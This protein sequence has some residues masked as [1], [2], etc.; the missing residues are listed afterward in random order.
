MEQPHIALFLLVVAIVIFVVVAGSIIFVLRRFLGHKKTVTTQATAQT[1]AEQIKGEY[2]QAGLPVNS[3]FFSSP[4]VTG[5]LAGI[6]FSH[7][8]V[9]GGRNS[10]PRIELSARSALRGDFAIRR[11]GGS[12]SFFKSIGIAGEAQTG[13]AAFDGEFY[14]AGTSR[15][16]V[17]A[18]FSDAQNRDAVRALFSLGF[19]SVELGD[20]GIT[21][22]R[23]GHGQLLELS[24]LRSALEQF[25]ALR[26]TPSAMQ[27]AIQGIGGI[28]TR[29]I[30]TAC[31]VALGVAVAA[32]MATTVLLEPMV[33]GQFG[34]FEDSWRSALIAYVSLVLVTLLMLRGR[35]NAPRELVMIALL[36]LP[37]IWVGAVS[38]AMLAN[39]YLDPSPPQTVRVVLL[40]H[41][42]SRG[43]NT[44]Y[45]FVFP[46]WGK[47]R[48]DVNIVVPFDI[49]G[50]ATKKQT[51][52]LH[53]RAGRYGY[54]WIDALKPQPKFSSTKI[55][56]RS[57]PVHASMRINLTPCPSLSTSAST[58]KSPS[59]RILASTVPWS[60]SAFRCQRPSGNFFFISKAE[61]P[62]RALT[63]LADRIAA[64]IQKLSL[65]TAFFGATHASCPFRMW[66]P[67]AASSPLIKVF[68]PFSRVTERIDLSVKP[69]HTSVLRWS[70]A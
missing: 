26:T 69:S 1:D 3:S 34:L 57:S 66:K 14:L 12:E 7:K 16:Y 53:T 46:P 61:S 58:M 18:L 28:N 35:A 63:T 51:W 36:G 67:S 13:D 8:I 30:N 4:S 15:E 54:E 11:E 22:S 52:I 2:A 6:A 37:S 31:A 32:F 70:R 47:R 17:Q 45:H 43:K 41:Y 55:G 33:D 49:Y 10:P 68:L 65:E 40:R 60:N 29:H 21:A 39:Q 44:S 59:K 9:P 38:G 23:S 50:K 42:A 48:S 5:T 19:D 62:V 24:A 56:C 25:A 64:A 20:A 27:V